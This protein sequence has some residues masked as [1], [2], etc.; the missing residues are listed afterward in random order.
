MNYIFI[1]LFRMYKILCVLVTTCLF[2]FTIS[3]QQKLTIRGTVTAEADHSPLPG[4]TA[5]VK[6]TNNGTTTNANGKFSI[7]AGP[8]DSLIFTYVGYQK[9]VTGINGQRNL[10]ITMK[11][12]VGGLNEVVV[13][14][15]G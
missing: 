1:R 8:K 12:S 3:A 2:S 6:G 10:E 11:A 13:V 14:A 5:V 9:L 15:Y 7:E 4:V